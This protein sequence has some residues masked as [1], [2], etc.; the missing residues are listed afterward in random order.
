MK[1]LLRKQNNAKRLQWAKVHK[2]W[3]I[4]QWNKVLWTEESKF[5]IFG[6][7]KR[8]YVWWRD[9][10]ITAT[11]S[12]TATVKNRGGSVV[13]CGTEE[14]LLT[15]A[16][17]EIYMRWMANWIRPAITAYCSITRSHLECGLLV[18]YLYSCKI[19]TKSI[20]VN[21]TRGTLKAKRNST[22]FNS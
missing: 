18:K 19:M 2:D 16:K 4:E 20:P 17:S 3:T 5:E 15:I 11:L 12:I 9:G 10:E 14:G 22:S 13:M 6:S 21:S 7:N 8:V 1:L